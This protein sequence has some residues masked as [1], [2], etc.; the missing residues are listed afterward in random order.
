MELE[1]FA[2]LYIWYMDGL[3]SEGIDFDR[4][5][6]PIHPP[7]ARSKWDIYAWMHNVKVPIGGEKPSLWDV[8]NLAVEIV[9]AI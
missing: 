6:L 4:L 5:N 9:R 8:R 3:G 1:A 7:F 2:P